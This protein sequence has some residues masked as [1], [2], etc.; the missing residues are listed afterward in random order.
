MSGSKTCIPILLVNWI[1]PNS[2]FHELAVRWRNGNHRS[3]SLF[4]DLVV[5]R[6]DRVDALLGLAHRSRSWT[7]L[8]EL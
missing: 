1:D 3:N 7:F 2:L 5:F 4:H 8:N 6:F